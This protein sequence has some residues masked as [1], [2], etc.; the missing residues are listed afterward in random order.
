LIIAGSGPTDRDGNQS[1]MKND[2]LKL[3]GQALAMKESPRYGTTSVGSQR[4]RLLHR[5]RRTFVLKHTSLT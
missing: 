1:L 3:L 4:A 2:S 5:Q